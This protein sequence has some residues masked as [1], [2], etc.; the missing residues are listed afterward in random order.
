[1]AGARNVART[2]KVAGAVAAGAA[3]LI[4][5]SLFQDSDSSTVVPPPSAADRQATVAQLARATGDGDICYGWELSDAAGTVVSQGSN[6]GDNVPADSDSRRCGSWVVVQAQVVYQPESSEAVDRA[7]I[8]VLG[9]PSL[10][11]GPE[12]ATRLGGLGLDEQAF[13]DDPGWAICRAALAL[14]LLAAEAGAAEPAATPSGAPAASPPPLAASGNDFWRDRWLYLVAAGGIV[15][16]GAFLVVIGI[17]ERQ[18]HRSARPAR[19]SARRA[20][21]AGTPV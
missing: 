20:A 4:A 9:S 6:L 14:P 8:S 17:F 16:V 18:A 5:F 3:G 11:I 2:L 19:K 1:M 7:N 21:R 15:L 12:L 10:R 13:I